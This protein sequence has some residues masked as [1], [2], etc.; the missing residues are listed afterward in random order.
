MDVANGPASKA[1]PAKANYARSSNK[2][3]R[4]KASNLEFAL[5]LAAV[6]VARFK[7]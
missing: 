7:V 2:Y 4:L 1:T 5:R 3:E 6:D